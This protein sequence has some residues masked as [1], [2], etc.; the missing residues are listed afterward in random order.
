[1]FLP[2][3]FLSQF[4]MVPIIDFLKGLGR[5]NSIYERNVMLHFKS[6]EQN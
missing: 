4:S 3:H 6:G 2:F 5:N 1:M